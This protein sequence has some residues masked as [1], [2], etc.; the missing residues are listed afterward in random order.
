MGCFFV[1]HDV[2]LFC[3]KTELTMGM[4]KAYMKIYIG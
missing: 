2:R 4:G 1:P 3:A